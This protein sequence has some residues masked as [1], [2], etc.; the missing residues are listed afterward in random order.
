MTPKNFHNDD[1][2]IKV[3]FMKRDT[4]ELAF[5]SKIIEKEEQSVSLCCFLYGSQC[6]KIIA[7]PF[8]RPSDPDIELFHTRFKKLDCK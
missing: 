1:S 5:T 6:E 2:V 3:V 7:H 8:K 4:L